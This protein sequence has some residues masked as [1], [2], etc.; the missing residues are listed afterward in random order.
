VSVT[1]PK[2]WSKGRENHFLRDQ[3]DQHIDLPSIQLFFYLV[4]PQHRK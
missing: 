3:D 2:C 4:C 1:R